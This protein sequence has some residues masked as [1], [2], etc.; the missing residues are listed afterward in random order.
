M[1][2]LPRVTAS[3]VLAAL[4]LVL[5]AGPALAQPPPPAP[6]PDGAKPPMNDF[7][8]AFY[9]CDGGAAFSMN[10]DSDQPTTVEMTANDGSKPIALKR[11][12][13]PS[14]VSFTGGGAKFWTDGKTVRVE[15]AKS[16]FNNC[17]MKAN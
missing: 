10:Y 9:R 3:R 16:A 7:Y 1:Y 5:T 11:S 17:K 6:A 12:P 14:G 2:A 15:G 13:S 4:A 8:Q